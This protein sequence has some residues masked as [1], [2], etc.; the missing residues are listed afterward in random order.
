MVTA[1]HVVGA[2]P[3]FIKM[4]PV[5]AALD[6]TPGLRQVVVHTGQHYDAAMSDEILS[7]LRFPVPDRFLEVG[8]GSHGAQTAKAL[9]RFEEVLFE[10]RPTLVVVAGD[11]N[12]TI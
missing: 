8:S 1:V 3:N 5:I 7:D 9:E 2:R 12:S 4:A 10:E 11:V 6:G